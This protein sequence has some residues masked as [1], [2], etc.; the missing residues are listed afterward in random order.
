MLIDLVEQYQAIIATVRLKK[1]WVYTP[2]R[3]VNL[4]SEIWLVQDLETLMK[5]F[6]AMNNWIGASS[7]NIHWIGTPEPINVIWVPDPMGRYITVVNA[8]LADEHGKT[9]VCVEGCGSLPNQSFRVPRWQ[10]ILLRG[11]ELKEGHFERVEYSYDGAQ[12]FRSHRPAYL[13]SLTY[14]C[15][16]QHEIDHCNGI[17]VAEKGR[18]ISIS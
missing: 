13:S 9:F 1:E 3:P 4:D 17:T 2:A 12:N 16:V 8:Q 15:I 11:F 10:N 18:D 7:N 5:G 6:A 14:Q